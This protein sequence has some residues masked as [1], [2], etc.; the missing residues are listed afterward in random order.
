MSEIS[1]YRQKLSNAIEARQD[2]IQRDVIP[3]LKEDLRVFQSSYTSLYSAFLKKGLVKEDPY[4]QEAKLNEIQVPQTENFSDN[5]KNEKMSNRLSNFDN[6]LDFLVN[7]YQFSVDFL[8]I[9]RIKKILGLIKF[10]DWVHLSRD[11]FSINTRYV[12]EFVSQVK[13]GHDSLSISLLNESMSSLVQSTGSI[14]NYLKT[15]T[16]FNREVY[17]LEVRNAITS[18]MSETETPSSTQIKK[19]FASVLPGKPFYPELIDEII[20]EDYGK[21]GAELRDVVLRSL[22]V[23]KKKQDIE[24]QEVPLKSFLIESI[25]SLS[26]ISNILIEVRLK[27]DENEALLENRKRSFSEKFRRFIQ[28]IF[29][30]EPE[31]IVYEIEYASAVRG[32]APVKAKLNFTEFRENINKRIKNLGQIGMNKSAVVAKLEAL[33]E[34]HLLSFLERNIRDLKGLTRDLNALDNYFKANIDQSNHN[35]MRGIK[36]E[37]SVIKNVFIKA[38]QK[39]YDY[40]ALK[41]EAEQ[42]K[43]LGITPK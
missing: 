6:Q 18:A 31:A 15:L 43:R 33:S 1:D 13:M 19:Q 30:N 17:K 42:F 20:K 41:E 26:A 34:Q 16:E 9:D 25:C 37:L 12:A 22:D 39:C 21:N 11:S 23:V 4:K 14:V 8:T 24:K 35:R 7:F 32:G 10:I 2:W 5:E 29:N 3:G 38:N 40:N 36:P 27:L 28:R